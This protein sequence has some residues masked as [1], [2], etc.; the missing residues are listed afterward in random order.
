MKLNVVFAVAGLFMIIVGLVQ[1]IAPAAMVAGAGIGETPSPAFLMTVRFTG[2]E[3]LGLGLIAWLVRNAEASKARDGIM[4]GF[5][6]YFAL[7]ALTSLYVQL[8]AVYTPFG[9]AVIVVQG[10]FAVGFLMAG[11]ASMSTS[12]AKRAS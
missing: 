1:L 4:L 3:L 8:T 9:W 7:H 10:L 5:T 6:L 11:R 12:L 2:V